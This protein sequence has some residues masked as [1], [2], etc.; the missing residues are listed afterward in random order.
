MEENQNVVPNEQQPTT[1]S[2]ENLAA[3]QPAAEE[4]DMAKQPE[5]AASDEVNQAQEAQVSEPNSEPIADGEANAQPV[6]RQDVVSVTAEDADDEE[7]EQ[8]EAEPDV[9]VKSDAELATLTDA[10]LLDYMKLLMSSK[11]AKRVATSVN[12]VKAQFV[13]RQEPAAE[14]EEPKLSESYVVFLELLKPFQAALAKEKEEAHKIQEANAEKKSKLLAKLTDLLGKI[15]ESNPSSILNDIRT[16]QNEWKEVGSVGNEHQDLRLN[17]KTL[18]DE[19]YSK[20]KVERELRDLDRKHN[21]DA[22]QLL[23][24]Q[25]E[26]LAELNSLQKLQQQSQAL[27]DSW[28]T[29]GP[30]GN[31]EENDQMWERFK[32][33]LNAV[34][35]KIKQLAGELREQEKVNLVEKTKLCEEAEALLNPEPTKNKEYDQLLSKVDDLRA[36]WKKIGRAPK[37]SNDAIYER[38]RAA[39]DVVFVKRRAFFKDQNSKYSENAKLKEQLCEQAEALKDSTDWKKTSELL[40]DLQKQWKEVGP[41]Q[42]RQGEN[43]WKRF[44]AACDAFFNRR[45]EERDSQKSERNEN[46]KKKK[47]LI[48]QIK[49]FEVPADQDEYL[50]KLKEFVQ[51]WN[52][53]GFVPAKDRDAING[54][55]SALIGKHFDALNLDKEENE[56]QRYRSKIEAMSADAS[57]RDRVSKERGRL[58]N[59]IRQAEQNI[60]TLENNI[61]FFAKS[62][63]SEGIIAEVRK[64]I[65]KAKNELAALNKKLALFDEN[66]H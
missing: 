38:F 48:E 18:M 63:S 62:K 52:S 51:E 55:Y 7:T 45:D 6:E 53:I 47:A 40:I 61:G 30:V 31:K 60:E 20:L 39:I 5:A 3:Q 14:G 19:Y 66:A 42:S 41:V 56:L 17:Y 65:E 23:C 35:K 9:K 44:R 43:L 28:K 27:R 54:E 33:A 1:E 64:N 10:E 2:M 34:S 32:T 8:D 26:A 15:T 16:I 59:Q 24:E 21:K 37:E 4:N 57:G 50:A 25:A 22:K 11:S 13:S 49:S 36:R 29:I 46:L 12:A 58:L